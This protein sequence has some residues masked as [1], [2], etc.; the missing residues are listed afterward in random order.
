MSLS[1]SE[2]L[3]RKDSRFQLLCGKILSQFNLVYNSNHHAW[4]SLIH[5]KISFTSGHCLPFSLIKFSFFL[6]LS[7]PFPNTG[8]RE[9]FILHI[10]LGTFWVLGGYSEI[11]RSIRESFFPRSPSSVRS[12]LSPN[13][14]GI[15]TDFSSPYVWSELWPFSLGDFVPDQQQKRVFKEE[16]H[17]SLFSRIQ[18]NVSRFVC[19]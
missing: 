16:N 5:F 1:T 11:I 15:K 19:S 9:T 6:Q 12:R 17:L 14:Q 8:H 13:L 7:T 2:L 18:C 3:R 10:C 4:I